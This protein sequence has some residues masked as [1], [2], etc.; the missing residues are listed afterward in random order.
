MRTE[1]LV[2]LNRLITSNRLKFLAVL[3]ADL[4]GVRHLILRFDP[5]LA[6]NL[7]CGMCF[8]SDDEWLEH[9]PIKRFSDDEIKR[10]ADMFFPQAMQLHIGCVA[11]PTVYKGYPFLVTLGKRY[12]I[13][14]IGFTTNGQLLTPANIEL[15]LEAGLDEITLSTH[16]IKK[17][18]YEG[19][20]R[21]AS[22]EKYHRNLRTLVDLKRAS[23]QKKPAIR[24]NYTVNPDNLSELYGFFDLFGEYDISTLQVRPIIDFGNTEYKNKTLTRHSAEYNEIVD[25]LI[26]ECHRRDISLLANKYDPGYDQINNFAVVYEKAVMRYLGPGK[27]WMDGFD[28]KSET[29]RE[30]M[31]RIGYRREL[32]RYVVQG[33][34]SL[35]RKTAFASSQLF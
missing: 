1:S 10:L 12:K 26:E 16:G 14:F 20:M 24:I 27:V 34:A 35:V 28:F 21:G 6:C 8:F 32:L 2:R 3:A 19:L 18:T 5:V 4:I 31:R 23:Q 7:R 17:D 15:M 25:F 13:P 29:Y 33:D 30:H 9:N 11:E 22:F